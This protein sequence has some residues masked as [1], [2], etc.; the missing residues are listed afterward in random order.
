[1]G[2][3]DGWIIIG[4]R[5]ETKGFEKQIQKLEDDL[6][7]LEQEY[8]A[9]SKAKPYDRQKEDLM[10]LSAK[11]EK[12]KNQ[13]ISLRKQQND[14]NTKG[15]REFSDSL[16]NAIK[17]IGKMAIAVFG[18]RT[19]FNAVRNAINIISQND[20]GLRADIDYIKGVLTYTLEPIVRRIVD[21]IKQ[22]MIY[23]G[24]IIKQWTGKDIFG[25]ASKKLKKAN[26]SAQKLSKTLAGFDEMN[27]VGGGDSGASGVS[28]SFDLAAPE[29]FDP[30]KWL[31]WIADNKEI[32]LGALTGIALALL[33]IKL[34][35]PVGWIELAI[36]AVA[37]LVGVIIKY[38]DE[39]KAA[40]GPA[41]QWLW[42]NVLSPAWEFIKD[43]GETIWSFIKLQISVIQ[44]IFTTLVNIL[45]SPFKIL[46]ETVTGVFN[47]IKTIVKGVF[48]VIKG[49]FTGDWKKVMEGF[50]SIF[51]GV[52]NTLWSI[53]KAPLN[54]I[55]DGINALIKGAN[56]I[57][58][59]VPDWVPVIGG[60]KLGFNLKTIPRLAK[61]GIVN[62]PGR[63]I[64]YAGANIAER[65]PEAVIPFTDEQVMD[66][67]GQS[68]AR[69]MTI[70]ATVVNSM[71]GR[72]LSREIQKI[73]NQGN[74]AMNR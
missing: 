31:V 33:A 63:G 39:I 73:Q 53:A 13:I 18:I 4:T 51:K 6:D 62:M 43:I 67:L 58:F 35:S 19:A 49:L 23:I 21:L 45:I 71:N 2:K 54:L 48:D 47:G 74:F 29:D 8:E 42:D 59:D 11:I 68:I 15:F 57:Q 14:V 12:T 44:G 65:A 1:M 27:V 16:G 55:I 22:M 56:K 38:W 66:R 72:V 40:L 9:L 70:N 24:Y 46:K 17:R 5:L 60:K 61:G 37:T 28:S 52:F 69:H 64:N 30:P 36:I 41:A 50:K 25:D 7:T 26:S 32:I 34:A 20:E 10:E 3:A